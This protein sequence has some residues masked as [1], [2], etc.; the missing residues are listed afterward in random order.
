M[1]K[2]VFKGYRIISNIKADRKSNFIEVREITSEG[3]KK[4]QSFP[5][6][7]DINEAVVKA[8]E[9]VNEKKAAKKVEKEEKKAEKNVFIPIDDKVEDVKPA[10]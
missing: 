9:F 8:K 5:F 2:F 10:A 7:D 3:D 1:V 4:I 6:T